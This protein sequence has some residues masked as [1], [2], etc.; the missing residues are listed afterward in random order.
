MY[1]AEIQTCDLLICDQMLYHWAIPTPNISSLGLCCSHL[2][3]LFYFC[4]CVSS[5]RWKMRRHQKWPGRKSSARLQRPCF[6]GSYRHQALRSLPLGLWLLLCMGGWNTAVGENVHVELFVSP[7]RHASFKAPAVS[8]G[9]VNPSGVYS[10]KGMVDTT[11]LQMN[12]G[13]LTRLCVSACVN[14]LVCPPPWPRTCLCPSPSLLC[15]TWPTRR[16]VLVF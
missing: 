12:N 10:L 16:W 1:R 8:W 5:R 15:S 6:K 2:L 7:N 14:H 13:A 4:H 9:N 11:C 3:S